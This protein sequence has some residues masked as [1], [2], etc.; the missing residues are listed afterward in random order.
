[1]R[2][3]LITLMILIIVG[4]AS[5]EKLSDYERAN[6][7]MFYRTQNEREYVRLWNSYDSLRRCNDSLRGRLDQANRLL[8]TIDANITELGEGTFESSGTK[9]GGYIIRIQKESISCTYTSN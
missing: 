1:M 3:L 2:N 5:T 4:C 9:V 8:K 6:K 7:A